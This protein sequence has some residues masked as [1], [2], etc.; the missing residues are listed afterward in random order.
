M[1]PLLPPRVQAWELLHEVLGELA[2]GL[3]RLDLQWSGRLG[4]MEWVA[5]LGALRSLELDAPAVV[6]S[7]HLTALSR[8]A[9]L[10]V[11]EGGAG[12]GQRRPGHAWGRAGGPPSGK[13]EAGRS[14][15]LL[16]CRCTRWT[17]QLFLRGSSSQTRRAP[18]RCSSNN[19]N[20]NIQS[21]SR[22]ADLLV[23]LRLNR[24]WWS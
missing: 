15:T 12:V 18:R 8:L 4:S 13:G 24:C 2:V 6:L 1:L 17:V 9:K 23:V 10:A 3:Q 20:S 5:A 16:P 22:A 14:C 7:S 21:S 19:S 11:G